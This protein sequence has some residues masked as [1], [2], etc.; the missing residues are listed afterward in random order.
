MDKINLSKKAVEEYRSIYADVYGEEL[1]NDEALQ[2]AMR[3][4]RLF[5]IIYKPIKRK[6][7]NNVKA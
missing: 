5:K 3:L 2:Q 1:S 4:L 7:L 6:E